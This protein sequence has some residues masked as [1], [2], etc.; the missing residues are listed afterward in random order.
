MKTGH[1]RAGRAKL[2]IITSRRKTMERHQANEFL[3]KMVF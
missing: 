3:E 1:Q 2:L